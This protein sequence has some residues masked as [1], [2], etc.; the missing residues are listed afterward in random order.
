MKQ[1]YTEIILTN[2]KEYHY[3][4]TDEQDN[5]ICICPLI[6]NKSMWYT[7]LVLDRVNLRPLKSI[8]TKDINDIITFTDEKLYRSETY[9]YDH[10]NTSYISFPPF[11]FNQYINVLNSNYYYC[12]VPC[13]VYEGILYKSIDFMVK[14]SFITDDIILCNN[15]IFNCNEEEI[16]FNY[17]LSKGVELDEAI[18]IINRMR[19]LVFNATYISK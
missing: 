6:V 2:G 14:A 3:D 9:Y 17:L 12:I 5:P 18:S 11:L 4:F 10:I 16:T 19:D 1:N 15:I 13:F 7:I 8:V